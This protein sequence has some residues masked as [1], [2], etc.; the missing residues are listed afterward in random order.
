MEDSDASEWRS[1]MSTFIIRFLM[2]NIYISAIVIIL[3]LT[4]RLFKNIFSSRMQYNLWF[5]LLGL[6]VI[7]FLPIKSLELSQIFSWINK[8][9]LPAISNSDTTTNYSNK[10]ITYNTTNWMNDFTISVSSNTPSFIE[11][12][13]L[14]IWI[15]GIIIMIIFTI[16]S[17]NNLNTI[18]NSSLPLQNKNV[19]KLYKQCLKE[20]N[21][22]KNIPIYSSAFLE[23]PII[24]G[25]FKPCIYLPIHLI[26]DYNA[27]DIRYML[28]HELQH[29]KYKD[30]LANYIMNLAGILYWFNPFVL[31]ALK[32]MCNDREIACDTSVLNMLAKESYE[33][34]GN[35]LI[36]FA[37]KLS[38]T[39]FPFA[40]SISGNLT[41]IKR[42]ILNIASYKSP[43]FSKKIISIITFILTAGCLLSLS[44]LLST[45][46]ASKEQY[47]WN[48]ESKNIS[49]INL[50]PYFNKYDGC[51]VLYN[52]HD[53]SWKIYNIEHATTRTSP[54]S[55]YKIYSALFGLEENIITPKNSLIHWNKKR[56]IFNAWNKDH[57]LYTAMDS[58][59]NWYFQTIDNELG[60]SNIKKYIDKINY[61][62]RNVHDA[63]AS[64]WMESTLKISPIEQ[65]ELLS[66]V[67]NNKFDFKQNNINTVKQA[68]CLSSSENGNFYG[69]TG[70]GR[71]NGQ[72]ING[73]FIGFIETSNNTYYF[74]TNINSNRNA[75]GSTAS[76]ITMS[77]LT[78]MN[79]WTSHS[80]SAN[81]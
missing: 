77:I 4:K 74:A 27:T 17:R 24:V 43:S 69:K 21:I 46:A 40:T 26:S 75:T 81:S 48:T 80:S 67:Y 25:L 35:T 73:W 61:G 57:N 28:L 76:K 41:Q 16:K 64:Y 58:S 8:L 71:V 47:K 23:S 29:Y 14:I 6:L 1:N 37:E 78:D 53:D 3:S 39:P 59:V 38:R 2:C 66:K 9:K 60:K 44:P 52:R 49:Y 19:H 56:Y 30:A 34:Y 11:L 68:I 7:P 18:K 12:A 13:L 20:M 50:S 42:R 79:I 70:T 15:I 10:S 45:Y 72:D 5:I 32:E 62:N 51:F 36:N 54:D 55:T 31:Y 22:T 33:E 63:L 65:V